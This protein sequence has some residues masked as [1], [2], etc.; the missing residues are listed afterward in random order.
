VGKDPDAIE[1]EIEDARARMGERVDALTYKA[2]VP[3]RV[4]D[5]LAGTRESVGRKLGDI[6]E[7]ASGRGPAAVDIRRHGRR[8]GSWM[9]ENP[10]LLAAGAV[11]A[12]VLAGLA[13]PSTRLEDERMGDVADSVRE[14]VAE[15][16]REAVERGS[17]I[18][19]AAGETI[20]ESVGDQTGEMAENVRQRASATVEDARASSRDQT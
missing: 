13:L 15:T 11:A 16:G 4:G 8:A 1:Q 3:R 9:R 17:R 14:R 6:A 19:E 2:D 10:L 5:K 18:A 12:G 7:Q 20:R